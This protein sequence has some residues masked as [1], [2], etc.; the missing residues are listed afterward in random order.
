MHSTISSFHLRLMLLPFATIVR[1]LLNRWH[2]W[3]FNQNFNISILPWIHLNSIQIWNL[4]DVIISHNFKH[5]TNN[6]EDFT[7]IKLWRSQRIGWCVNM[8]FGCA[9]HCFGW[10]EVDRFV[11]FYVVLLGE[12]SFCNVANPPIIVPTHTSHQEKTVPCERLSI[13]FIKM[14]I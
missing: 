10:L 13:I 3:A 4:Q 8:W 12:G 6:L 1:M 11:I 7:Y 14:T 2:T 5:N 9:F